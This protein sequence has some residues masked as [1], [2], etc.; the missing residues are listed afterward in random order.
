MAAAALEAL[1][2][3]PA[4]ALAAW[5]AAWFAAG[6]VVGAAA[7][8]AVG[9]A[10]AAASRSATSVNLSSFNVGATSGASSV[11]LAFTCSSTGLALR[12]S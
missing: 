2:A 7:L 8:L 3:L 12:A 6:S 11:S 9:A 1:A 4:A 10:A 5:L